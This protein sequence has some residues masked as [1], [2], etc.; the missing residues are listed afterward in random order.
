MSLIVV[1]RGNL[2]ESDCSV[3]AHQCNCFST[4]GAGIAKQFAAKWP[5]VAAADSAF[6]PNDPTGKLGKVSHALVK[7]DTVIVYNLYGQYNYGRGKQQTNYQALESAVRMMLD[8]LKQ[9]GN[10]FYQ[11]KI[12]VPYGMGCGLAGG[13]WNVVSGTLQSIAE[14]YG[15]KIYAYQL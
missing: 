15:I 5:E 2:L 9:L 7:N 4:M 14:E 6:R 11:L 1:I 3:M 13:D 8:E 12:G 10:M